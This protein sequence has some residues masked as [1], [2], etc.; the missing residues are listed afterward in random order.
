MRFLSVYLSNYI[1]IYNGMGLYDIH[2]DMTKCKNRITIIRG[3]NGSG[4]YTL[5]KAMNLFHDSS[6]CFIPGMAARKEIVLADNNTIY[7]LIFIHGV[8]SN[9]ERETTKAYIT[10]T[11]GDN[12]VELNE[13]GN[14]SSYKDILYNEL[15]LDANFAALSQLSNDDRG[16]ADK[17]P[18]DRKRFVNSIISSL[19]TYNNIYK[20]LNKRASN[21]KSMINSITGKLSVLG[22]ESTIASNLEAVEG[23]INDL[24]DKKDKAV[25]ALAKEQSTIQLLDPD[26]S[27]QNS[28]TIIT[29]ELN[30]ARKNFQ[31]IQTIIDSLC[32]DYNINLTT[33]EDEYKRIVD[34]KN[35]MIIQNQINRNSIESLISQKDSQTQYLNQ[36]LYRLQ[37]LN[38][39]DSYEEIQS[40]L[41]EYRQQIQ[42]IESQ[43][44]IIGI[45]NVGDI[46]KDEYILALEILS[47]LEDS[48]SA[49]KSCMYYE[50][51]E[52]IVKEYISTGTIPMPINVDNLNTSDIEAQIVTLK[53]ER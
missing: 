5:P 29:A 14:V 23:K 22:D 17:R 9:G 44:R 28:N 27:I 11:F 49:F 39:G 32:K 38:N 52:G 3:D 50:V 8:K 13:N 47:D 20:T 41:K 12:I 18:A 34:A 6:D 4:K 10:K 26:G 16:L 35:S 21:F 53:N 1:G 15:G 37:Q 42:D 51:I 25:V 7:K 48:I 24:Q 36:K 40:R 2:I 19:D 45:E 33:L 46:S 30:L 31:G 43:M